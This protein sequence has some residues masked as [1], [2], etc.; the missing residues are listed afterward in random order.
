MEVTR[1]KKI[2]ELFI[3]A[4][5]LTSV[6]RR[7][8]LEELCLEDT[9]LYREVIDLLEIDN[10]PHNLLDHCLN[11]SELPNILDQDPLSFGN[12]KYGV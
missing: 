1:W 8:Y 6:K 7:E 12:I 11:R 10:A 4:C 2:E 9:E 3:A 5:E